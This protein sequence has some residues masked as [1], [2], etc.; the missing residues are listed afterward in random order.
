[1][2][3]PWLARGNRLSVSSVVVMEGQGKAKVLELFGVERRVLQSDMQIVGTVQ[4]KYKT[5]NMKRVV[6]CWQ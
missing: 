4:L 1:V 6:G 5:V 3:H 2:E